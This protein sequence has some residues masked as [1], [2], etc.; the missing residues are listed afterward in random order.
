MT[1][2][3]M[4]VLLACGAYC[5]HRSDG[6]EVRKHVDDSLNWSSLTERAL[7]HGI[8]PLLF[9]A[10][11]ATSQDVMPIQEFEKLRVSF[12]AMANRNLYLTGELLKLLRLFRDNDIPATPFKGPV[13]SAMLFGD[14]TFREFGD[15]DILV[16]VSNV[17]AA[18]DL[19]LANGYIA[20]HLTEKFDLYMQFGHEVD[21][22][23]P[24]GNVAVDLQW[25]FA[26][27]WV[28]FPI[29]LIEY[30][31]RLESHRI[32]G[33][34]VWQPVPEDLLLVL[35]GHGYRHLWAQ[36]KWIVDIAG[37]VNR[38]GNAVNWNILL[39]RAAQRGGLR[40]VLLGLY[41]AQDLLGS[42]L[43]GIVTNAIERDKN[44]GVLGA[45]VRSQ[46]LESRR[47]A[48]RSIGAR[49]IIFKLLF[50][51]KARERW[52]DKFPKPIP[53]A[54]CAIYWG[55]RYVRHYSRRLSRLAS[56]R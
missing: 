14:L 51:L 37:F 52:R 20:Q 42:S 35:C 23:R 6:S 13:L 32:G 47:F 16:D 38:F 56:T 4:D 36:L 25:R 15:L 53:I 9:R 39:T 5:V 31:D 29:D 1:S 27:E 33:E 55:Q 22:L 54:K 43:P 17:T 49:N 45:F 19:L 21:L 44:I 48:H 12:Q 28:A 30:W 18:R 3:E 8:T 40:I 7:H 2:R 41:L 46:F 34:L 10:L 50:H 26:S 11:E 24:T